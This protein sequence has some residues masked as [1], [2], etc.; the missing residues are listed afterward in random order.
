MNK[1]QKRTTHHSKKTMD[2]LLASTTETPTNKQK[3]VRNFINFKLCNTNILTN[4][5]N[6]NHERLSFKPTKAVNKKAVVEPKP[7][8]EFLK[9]TANF[10]K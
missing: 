4:K 3:E 7:S 2:E 5:T 10:S 1:L 6:F 8:L 9:S